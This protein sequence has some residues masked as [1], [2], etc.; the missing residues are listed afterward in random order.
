MRKQNSNFE[1]KFIS[2]EGSKIKNNDYFGYVELDE[3][4][5]YVIADG[6][7]ELPDNEG[8][9]LAIETIIVNF[10]S[11]PSI[12]RHSVKRLLKLANRVLLGK[13]SYKQ[14]KASV[15]VVV[16]DYQK[17]RYGYAGNTRLRIYRGGT[18]YEQTT[19]MSLSQGMVER[20]EIPK[21]EVMRHEERNNLYSYL[22]MKNFRPVISKKIKL[23][24]T[25][26]IALYTRGIWENV[27]E[28]ELDDVFEEADNEAQ[29]TID[30]IEDILLSRQPENLDNYTLAVIF[31]NKVYQNPQKRKRI[32]KIILI[33]VIALVIL[34]VICVVVWLLYRK[35]Q[36]Q[37]EDM[38]YYFTSTIEYINTDNYVRAQE[39]CTQAQELAQKLR[40]DSM[41]NRLQEY[42]IVIETVLLADESYADGDYEEANGYYLSAI[43][44]ARYAD[45]V[46]TDYMEKKLDKIS[47]FLSVEDEIALGDALMEQGDYEGA[48]E[49]YLLAKQAALSVHDV[50]GKQNAMDAL[51]K[52]YQEKASAESEAQEAADSQ[53]EKEVAAAEMMAAGD[54]AC[55]EQ[56]Y[57]GAKVYYTM[58]ATK[59][60]ELEDNV[61]S[62]MAEEK[63]SAVEEKLAEQDDKRKRAETYEAQGLAGRQSGDLWGAKSQYMSAKS[64]Y[65]ELGS[66]EDVQRI[67]DIL[68]EIDVQIAQTAG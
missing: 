40:D 45:N 19:D 11:A 60:Q 17:M 23:L 41:K 14:L 24:E 53:A 7:T 30:S 34:A 51:E 50:E 56:D 21:D 20:E 43:D 12:S 62:G 18:V 31:I 2:E 13:E 26:I 66:D 27:H 59:Y 39:E 48:E 25:D 5:C 64:I 67:T 63:L 6:I 57:T 47:I 68:A 10:Q 28:A 52:L 37:R 58:A 4:A 16:T 46:G 65:Q 9:K 54:S 29:G 32:K 35:K 44:R 49:K 36:Q 8:A 61:L 3:F 42:L 1:A 55:L 15:T 33:S 22:G 38:N